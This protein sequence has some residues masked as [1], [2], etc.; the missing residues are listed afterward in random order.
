MSSLSSTI[1]GNC[2]QTHDASSHRVFTEAAPKWV[3]FEEIKQMT[4][5]P[6]MKRLQSSL[7]L[8]CQ[9][10]GNPRPE[11]EWRREGLPVQ[12]GFVAAHRPWVLALHHLTE[13]DSGQYSCFVHNKLGRLDAAFLVKVTDADNAPPEFDQGDPLNSTVREGQT[14]TFQC[15]VRS[16][17][18]PLIRVSIYSRYSGNLIRRFLNPF[19]IMRAQ[20]ADT[21]FRAC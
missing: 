1:R 11:V 9:T 8:K 12:G 21:Q 6:I 16:S 3:D 17:Y 5:A 4:E 18:P 13:A 19:Q 10:I 2:A 7:E 14:A 20:L 15:K